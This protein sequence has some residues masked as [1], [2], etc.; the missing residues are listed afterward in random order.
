MNVKLA[1]VMEASQI[2]IDQSIGQQIDLS[3]S[4]MEKH[5]KDTLDQN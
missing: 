4:K 5:I 1:D 2:R 3:T